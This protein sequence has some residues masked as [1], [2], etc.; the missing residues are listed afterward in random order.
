MVPTEMVLDVTVSRVTAEALDGSRGFLPRHIDFVTVLDTGIL[1]YT[2][3]SGS[4]GF[5]ALDGGVLVKKGREFLVSTAGAV[6]APSLGELASLI[7]RRADE[8]DAAERE[9]RGTL[10]RLEAGLVKRLLELI[11]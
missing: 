8:L 3:E 10:A 7:R 9:A 4:E 2:S 5:V 11:R 6:C 1:A